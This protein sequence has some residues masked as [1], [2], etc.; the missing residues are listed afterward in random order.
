VI[1]QKIIGACS[2]SAPYLM[3]LLIIGWLIVQINQRADDAAY[4]Y[5]TAV[6]QYGLINAKTDEEVLALVERWK[7]DEWGAQIGALRVLCSKSVDRVEAIGGQVL[8][9]KMCRIVR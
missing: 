3:A 1:K 2:S 9:T 8:A 7:R 6:V 5:P 4:A